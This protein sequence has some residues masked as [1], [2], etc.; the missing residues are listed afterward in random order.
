MKYFIATLFSVTLL[1]GH[2]QSTYFERISAHLIVGD[3]DGAL[4]DNARALA[5]YPTSDALQEMMIRVYSARGECGKAL[6]LWKLRHIDNPYDP[7][8]DFSLVEALAWGVLQGGGQGS[9]MHRLMALIGAYLTQDHRAVD[10]LIEQLHS[11]NAMLRAQAAK[12]ASGYR[13]GRLQKEL[14]NRFLREKNWFVRLE[15]INTIGRLHIVR[16][17]AK[18]K[19]IVASDRTGSEERAAAITALVE[20][21]ETLEVDE[22]E[23][24]CNSN[25]AGL[26]SLACSLALHFHQVQALDQIFACLN[27]ASPEVRVMALNTIHLLDCGLDSEQ[28]K[29]ILALIEDLHPQ[30]A[31]TAAWVGFALDPA[32]SKLAL[33]RWIFDTDSST[34]RFA[35]GALAVSGAEASKFAL[36]MLDA[37]SDPIVRANLAIGLLRAHVHEDRAKLAL[38]ELLGDDDLQLMFDHSHNPMIRVLES[39]EVRHVP[40]IHNYPQIVDSLTRIELLSMLSV[41]GCDDSKELMAGFL[42]TKMHII[43]GSAAQMLIEEGDLDVIEVIRDLLDDPDDRIAIQAALVLAF[44]GKETEMVSR[45]TAAYDRAGWEMR[46]T[47]L[48]ALG[49]LGAQEVVPFLLE[50]MN[51]PFRLIRIVAASSLIQCL[52]H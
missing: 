47:I 30:V 50:K 24:L 32:A 8:G 46:L 10:A 9:E 18:L 38:K 1:F 33:E 34:A 51:E 36:E 14:F 48:E 7:K 52:Y 44:V 21:T 22:L 23:K 28:Q 6:E 25:R 49:H 31:I 20:M 39:N 42:K 27:D 45:L 19:E 13:D 26:R 41:A 29:S 12:M 11:S 35:A 3:L 37:H 5:L 40:H 4:Q 17:R 2:D 16:A 43:I 15:L